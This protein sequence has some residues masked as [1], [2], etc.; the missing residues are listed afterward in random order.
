M[1][2]PELYPLIDWFPLSQSVV[3]HPRVI[4]VS[5]VVSRVDG[6]VMS[7]QSLLG[8]QAR[9]V[10]ISFSPQYDA[11]QNAGPHNNAHLEV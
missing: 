6:H 5:P 3:C 10:A 8:D 9:T 11:D 1:I 2:P 7:S 4:D